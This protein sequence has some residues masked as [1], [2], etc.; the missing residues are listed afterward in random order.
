MDAISNGMSNEAT[1]KRWNRALAVLAWGG[2][3]WAAFCILRA[4]VGSEFTMGLMTDAGFKVFTAKDFTTSQRLLLVLLTIPQD[5]CWVYC[6]WQVVRLSRHFAVSPILSIDMIQCL[7]RFG[8][9]LAAQAVF[10]VICVPTVAATLIGIGKLDSVDNM[11]QHMV[12]GGA[13]TSLMA[14]VL[15]VVVTNLLRIGV[16]LREEVELTI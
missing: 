10:E 2:I 15:I 11:W 9:G 16:R 8:Y 12:G 14:A 4:F 3:A 6:L 5:L 7:E 13:L 1:L